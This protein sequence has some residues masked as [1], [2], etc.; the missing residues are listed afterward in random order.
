MTCRVPQEGREELTMCGD[1]RTSGS[2]VQR[3][4]AKGHGGSVTHV[5]QANEN[6]TGSFEVQIYRAMFEK[7]NDKIIYLGI[8]TIS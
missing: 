8:I 1:E 5:G 2:P 6:T 3:T 7:S 4:L